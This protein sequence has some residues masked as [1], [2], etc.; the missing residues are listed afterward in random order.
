M[1]QREGKKK[2]KPTVN[3]CAKHAFQKNGE[4]KSGSRQAHS[5]GVRIHWPW[6]I[7]Y[8]ASSERD[9][10]KTPRVLGVEKAEAAFWSSKG[11]KRGPRQTASVCRNAVWEGEQWD[12]VGRRP[13]APG[14]GAK[15]RGESAK[16]RGFLGPREAVRPLLR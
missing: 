9:F 7:T 8:F 16:G 11:K 10:W 4:R 14:S 12:Q 13:D 5:R 6:N 1:R 3:V 15:G 2:K